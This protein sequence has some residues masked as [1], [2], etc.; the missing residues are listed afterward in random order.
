MS[1]MADRT[2]DASMP[3]KDHGSFVCHAPSDADIQGKL[4]YLQKQKL[5]SRIYNKLYWLYVQNEW[6]AYIY[7]TFPNL[8]ELCASRNKKP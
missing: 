4:V 3:V 2:T 6:I 7:I 5:T 8:S 1:R